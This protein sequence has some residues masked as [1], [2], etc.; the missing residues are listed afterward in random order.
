VCRNVIKWDEKYRFWSNGTKILVGLL[1]QI[2]SEPAE[3]DKQADLPIERR[4]YSLCTRKESSEG[5]NAIWL[6]SSSISLSKMLVSL[7]NWKWWQFI[8][9]TVAY[10]HRLW[11]YVRLDRQSCLINISD[12][13]WWTIFSAEHSHCTRVRAQ[14][15]WACL[16]TV[17]YARQACVDVCDT[18]VCA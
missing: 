17:F 6:I 1:L 4:F 18:F 2:S 9:V 11:P 10:S 14:Q 15:L 7:L 3:Q 16:A 8:M 13:V 5:T 12:R